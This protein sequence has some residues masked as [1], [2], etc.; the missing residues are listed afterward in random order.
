MK[1]VT[2]TWVTCALIFNI[3]FFRSMGMD[4]WAVT[5]NIA[6]WDCSSSPVSV[7][8]A[9]VLFDDIFGNGVALVELSSPFT[10][11]ANVPVDLYDLSFVPGT[12]C[13]VVGWN[14][15]AAECEFI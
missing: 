6:H 5:L 13:S 11:I 12:E 2:L 7:E 4:G 8:V 9:N 3:S 14:S 1:S 15:G 10:Y